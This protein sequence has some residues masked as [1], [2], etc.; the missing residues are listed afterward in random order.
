VQRALFRIDCKYT[1]KECLHLLKG[2]AAAVDKDFYLY[3]FHKVL[4]EGGY[5][6]KIDH[7]TKVYK[8]ATE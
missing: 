2:Y 1:N 8:I 3:I 6:S 4:N 5:C 7:N